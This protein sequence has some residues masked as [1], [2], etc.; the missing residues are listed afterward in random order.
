MHDPNAHGDKTKAGTEPNPSR[1]FHDA[2]G[3]RWQVFEKA[4]DA[5]D[6]RSG[7]SLIF[8]SEVAMR[9]V[10]NYPANWMELTDDELATLSWGL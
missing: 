8:V 9:R 1:V 4:F 2:D 7:A 3:Q 6:R 10:R 5:F